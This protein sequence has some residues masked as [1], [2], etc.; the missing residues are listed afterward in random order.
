MSPWL[1]VDDRVD[2]QHGEWAVK[3]HSKYLESN[4]IRVSDE[5]PIVSLA[6]LSPYTQHTTTSD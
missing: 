1:V 2:E 5:P 6:I 4:D 3:R